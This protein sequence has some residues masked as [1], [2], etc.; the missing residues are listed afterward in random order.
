MT[1]LHRF[2]SSDRRVWLPALAGA[3]TVA[4]GA[5]LAESSDFDAAIGRALFRRA[6]TPAPSST[7]A[8]DGLGPLFNARA[9]TSCHQG[10]DRAPLRVGR[11]GVLENE[12]L[13]LRI[14][15]EQGRGDPIYGIQLQTSA[16]EGQAAEGTVRIGRRGL[17]AS[18][19]GY[20]PLAS[21]MRT[22]GRIAPHLWGLGKLGA[23]PQEVILRLA[24]PEDRNDDGI[25]GRANMVSAP[26]Q[27]PKLGRFGWKAQAESI[28]A[29]TANAFF[30]DMGLA[31]GM[32]PEPWGDCTAKQPACRAA[33]HGGTVVAPEIDALILDRIASYL[34]SI[35]APVPLG[36]VLDAESEAQGAKLF[37]SVGCASCH[38]PELPSP[39][40]PVRAFTDLLLHDLGPELDGGA[41]EP[42]VKS[43]EWRT[44]PLWGLS[45]TLANKARLLH[46]ARAPTVEHA[47][48]LHGGE[49]AGA[50]SRFLRLSKSDRKR[51][52][53]YVSSL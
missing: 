12:D 52:L 10:L 51:L 6:W 14:S 36:R 18:A 25:R 21:A 37:A 43:T 23:V 15:D 11:G 41:T 35:P 4:S 50:R 45:R 30:A 9:C 26:G 32:H 39:E 22:G 27:L 13:V 47:V 28:E 34:A 42:G 29:Q 1:G 38:V 33:P 49:A 40:G 8:N 7:R 44:A 16:V 24:D 3:L 2:F 48:R 53:D 46:D 19:L 17:E 5:V 20:G 31:S